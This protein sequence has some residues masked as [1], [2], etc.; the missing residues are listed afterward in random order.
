M[1]FRQLVGKDRLLQSG[2]YFT[3]PPSA[4]VIQTIKGQE[5]N[6]PFYLGPLSP[7]LVS[8][9]RGILYKIRLQKAQEKETSF[10]DLRIHTKLLV[11]TRRSYNRWA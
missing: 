2:S 1:A 9:R 11:C 3:H 7:L 8:R 10:A 5:D 6:P 4:M